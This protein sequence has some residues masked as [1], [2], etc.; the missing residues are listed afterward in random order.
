[1]PWQSA[2]ESQSPSLVAAL[3]GTPLVSEEGG[4][5]PAVHWLPGPGRQQLQSGLVNSGSPRTQ[6]R[7]LGSGD[8]LGAAG[9]Q[10]WKPG[11]QGDLQQSASLV[12]SE[13][14]QLSTPHWRLARQ[15]T[16]S[17]QSPWVC[18]LGV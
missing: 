16:C 7:P 9:G 1:M 15:S 14:P 10:D 3:E 18:S 12:G 17:S 5:Y 6:L 2:S 8:P 11:S 13:A 4:A